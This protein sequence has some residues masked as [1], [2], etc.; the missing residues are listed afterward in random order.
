[1]THKPE[2]MSGE[3]LDIAAQRRNELKQLFPEYLPRPKMLPVMSCHPLT[4]NALR[5][6]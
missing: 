6:N 5:P 2:V 3:S 1:M 4:L